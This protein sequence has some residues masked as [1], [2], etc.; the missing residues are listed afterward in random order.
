[1]KSRSRRLMWWLRS[2]RSRVSSKRSQLLLSRSMNRLLVRL[3]ENR[4]RKKRMAWISRLRCLRQR[5]MSCRFIMS[6]RRLKLIMRSSS[7]IGLLTWYRCVRLRLSHSGASSTSLSIFHA[8]SQRRRSS[9]HA[10]RRSR[11]RWPRLERQ[12]IT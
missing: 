4:S 12:R 11:R 3:S 1:M 7:V 9:V 6:Q 8:K 5:K 10:V 2:K